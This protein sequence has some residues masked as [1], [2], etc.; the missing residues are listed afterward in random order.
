MNLPNPGRSP[1]TTVR[2]Q[3]YAL[4]IG[5]FEG[6]STVWLLENILTHPSSTLTYVDTFAGGAEHESQDLTDL[7]SRFRA[8]TEPHRAKLVARKGRSGR[9]S[10]REKGTQLISLK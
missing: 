8:N 5:V 9:A 10:R 3:S 7:E 6:R 1:R 2:G 4:E